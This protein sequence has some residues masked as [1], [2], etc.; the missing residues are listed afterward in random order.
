MKQWCKMQPAGEYPAL[1]EP[2]FRLFWDG[3]NGCYMVTEPGIEDVQV[4]TDADMR[5]YVDA[6]RAMRAQAAP[7]ALCRIFLVTEHHAR[8]GKI[9]PVYGSSLHK[10]L[11]GHTTREAAERARTEAEDAYNALYPGYQQYGNP[12]PKAW[13][14]QEIDVIPPIAAR[15]QAKEGQSYE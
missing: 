9:V 14:I 7:A 10:V 5:A 3:G 15:A 13:V 6:D 12:L 8:D 4:Y 1:P 11:S 2:A